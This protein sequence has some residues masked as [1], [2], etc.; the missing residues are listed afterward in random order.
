MQGKKLID[1]IF[2]NQIADGYCDFTP[3]FVYLCSLINFT[4]NDTK[5]IERR[6]SK[7]FIWDADEIELETKVNLY[8]AIPLNL[9]LWGHECWAQKNPGHKKT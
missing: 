3:N 9:A 7:A 5:D 2:N 6:I 1:E 4:L 8:K